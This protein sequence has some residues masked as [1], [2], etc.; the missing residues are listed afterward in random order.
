MVYKF[1]LNDDGSSKLKDAPLT[2]LL[3]GASGLQRPAYF[4]FDKLGCPFQLKLTYYRPFQENKVQQ[5]GKIDPAR[6]PLADWLRGLTLNLN[7]EMSG[8]AFGST[9]KVEIPC[10]VMDL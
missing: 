6:R 8:Y 2:A 10:G 4:N 5:I 1:I 3:K 9:M 7:T